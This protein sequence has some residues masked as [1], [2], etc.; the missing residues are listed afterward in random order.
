MYGSSAQEESLC[1]E[2]YLYNVISHERFKEYY[3]WNRDHLNIGLYMNRMLLSPHI[4]FER[5]NMTKSVNV[6]TCA[7]PNYTYILKHVVATTEH[8]EY[9]Q[10]MLANRIK[11]ILL[12]L[13]GR[14]KENDVV[15]LGAFGCGVFRQDPNIVANFFKDNMYILGKCHVIFAVPSGY[16]RKD[17]STAMIFKN[18]VDSYEKVRTYDT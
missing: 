9:N 15:I 13:R 18:M 14:V 8:H 11:F 2:S 10:K 4:V 17:N 12:T 6:I 16:S 7:A 1:R 5:D 3:A